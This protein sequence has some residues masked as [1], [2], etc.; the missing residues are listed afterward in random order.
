ML[1]SYKNKSIKTI[2]ED[3]AKALRKHGE[4]NAGLIAL[5]I[6]QIQA[7]NTLVVLKT[8]PQLRFHGLTGQR[9]GQFAIDLY[10]GKRLIVELETENG[11]LGE[12]EIKEMILI[13]VTDYH[14]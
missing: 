6:Q 10:K 9:K 13:E 8:L 11:T 1:I 2:C 3:K 4:R 14:H 5:R 7:S 12:S